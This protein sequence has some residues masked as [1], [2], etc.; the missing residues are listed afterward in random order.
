MSWLGRLLDSVTESPEIKHARRLK[1]ECDI[2]NWIT[3]ARNPP[4]AEAGD[5]ARRLLATTLANA[6][7]P[8]LARYAAE[9]ILDHRQS[10]PD[11]FS[12]AADVILTQDERA[13]S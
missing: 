12:L 10:F 5:R 6:E 8:Y 9:K 13:A 7:Q 4:D 11:L 2:G 3:I 1:A